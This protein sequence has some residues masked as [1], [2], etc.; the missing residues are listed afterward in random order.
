MRHTRFAATHL[1]LHTRSLARTYALLHTYV[2]LGVYYYR[3]TLATE[4]LAEFH[5]GFLVTYYFYLCDLL[6][7]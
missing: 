1:L 5:T 2:E 6:F 7:Y 3:V 4:L